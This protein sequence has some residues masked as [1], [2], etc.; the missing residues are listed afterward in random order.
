MILQNYHT[1]HR[2]LVPYNCYLF[3]RVA[4]RVKIFETSF[5]Y[6]VL[7]LANKVAKPLTSIISALWCR[8]AAMTLQVSIDKLEAF[9]QTFW[10]NVPE[11][12]V[13]L[14]HAPMGAGKTTTIA[15][16]CRYKRV[17][18]APSSPTFSIINEYAFTENGREKIIFHIDLYRLNSE[19]EIRSTGVEECLTSGEICFVEWPEKAPQLFDE[20]ALHIT[21]EPVSD[22]VR[23]VKILTA[24]AHTAHSMTEQL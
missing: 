12:K 13:F 14:F 4:N 18:E 11:A 24:A 20:E 23:I 6:S 21:I 7:S 22:K 17:A 2:Q 19:E 8:F 16:L 5:H 9:A 15:A 1:V 10:S 3:N